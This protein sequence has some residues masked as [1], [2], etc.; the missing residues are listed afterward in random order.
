MDNREHRSGLKTL[1]EKELARE[2]WR[3]SYIRQVLKGHKDKGYHEPPDI[4]IVKEVIFCCARIHK[5]SMEGMMSKNKL[6]EVSQARHLCYWYLSEK[7]G[8]GYP[9]IAKWFG[10][11]RITVRHGIFKIKDLL[12]INDKQTVEQTNK[13]IELL[14]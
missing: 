12:E 7:L 2:E 13:L 14:K 6:G 5:L 9:T 10:W 3:P 1:I 8:Y 4:P 11:D